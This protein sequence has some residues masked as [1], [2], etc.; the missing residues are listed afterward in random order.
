MLKNQMEAARAADDKTLKPFN[1]PREQIRSLVPSMGGCFATDRV[2]VD[3]AKVGFMYREKP[4]RDDD[5]GWVFLAGDETQE[6]MDEQ[7]NSG[8]YAVN[9]ICNYDPEIIPFI[10]EVPP[11]AF[12]RNIQ[13]GAFERVEPPDRG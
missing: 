5:S 6:Y 11:C 3:G 7:W 4:E 8:I 9:T 2:L 1:L 13:T 10:N 12:E